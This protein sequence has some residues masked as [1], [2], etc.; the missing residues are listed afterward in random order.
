MTLLTNYSMY[1]KLFSIEDP[2][3]Y[4]KIW[5]LQKQIPLIILYNNLQV[6]PGLFLSAICPLKKKAKVD[7]AD[8]NAFMA[9]QLRDKQALFSS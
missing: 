7:P 8:I 6:N 4:Q 5:T 1:K 2:K 9:D 3:F